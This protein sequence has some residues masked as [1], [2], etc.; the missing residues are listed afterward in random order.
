MT[1]YLKEFEQYKHIKEIS[2]II[3]DITTLRNL[4]SSQQF[5]LMQQHI[6]NIIKKYPVET[7]TWN[8]VNRVPATTVDE[9]YR[10]AENFLKAK[11]YAKLLEIGVKLK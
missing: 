1:D 9:S 4:Y 11:G 2:D 6:T 10:N 8:A 7:Q 5:D 3:S